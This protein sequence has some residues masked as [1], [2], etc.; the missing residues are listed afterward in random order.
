MLSTTQ[1][2][3]PASGM[4]PRKQRGLAREG[5]AEQVTSAESTAHVAATP[6]TA[7]R[8]AHHVQVLYIDCS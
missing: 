5:E 6:E 4:Q 3:R 2:R 8:S 1:T 7:Q